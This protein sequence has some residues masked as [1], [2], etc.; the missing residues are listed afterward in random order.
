MVNGISHVTLIVRDVEKSADFFRT[1]LGGKEL[2]DSLGQP[3]SLSRE[4]FLLMGD[5]WLVLMQGEPIQNASYE[6]IAFSVSPENFDTLSERIAATGTKTRPGRQRIEG[7][8]RS[9][10]FFDP[11]GHLLEVHCG[12]M[13]TRLGVYR[14]QINRASKHPGP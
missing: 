11:D 4:K 6:H 12:D 9:I 2:Y 14:S 7:E 5:L 13:M 1:V 8:G 3:F 10:Y